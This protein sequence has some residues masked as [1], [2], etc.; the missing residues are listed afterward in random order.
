MADKGGKN[1]MDRI[2]VFQE[3]G[4][5][6]IGDRYKPP[7]IQFNA[8]AS[9]GKQMLPGGSKTRSALQSGYFM[10]K[11]GRVMEG[12]AYSDPIKVRRQHRLKESQRNIGKAFLPSS[13]E[14][15]PSGLGSHY[16][17]LGGPI[18]A[19]SPN[20][21][22]GKSYKS[23][24][25]NFLTNPGKKGT[26]FG[27]VAVTLGKYPNYLG[28]TYDV[29]KDIAKKELANHKNAVKGAA[30]RLNMHPKAYFDQNP[31]ASDKLLGR[32][33]VSAGVSK[34]EDVKPFKPSS[35]GKKPAGMKAGTF[36]P[37]PSHSADPYK[38]KVSRSVNVV[39]KTGKIFMPSQGPKSVPTNSIV[40]QNVMK[41]INVQNYRSVTSII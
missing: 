31:Y 25:K 9:K 5:V 14:K 39:N 24:G 33:S 34:K 32:R 27:Y 16:G 2:G 10:D 12:E 20:S 17:T 26:G 8:A 15:K 19:F 4:Y 38:I 36:D 41:T 11:F 13:G 21:R 37:Y 28:D 7:G 30:F 35:P 18:T 3:M 22:P 40:N 29:H 23:P 6:T 1:D